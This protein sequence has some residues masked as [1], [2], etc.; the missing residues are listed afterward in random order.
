MRGPNSIL[1]EGSCN[2]H[3][4]SSKSRQYKVRAELTTP[5]A[6][7]VDVLSWVKMKPCVSE[8]TQVLLLPGRRLD[9]LQEAERTLQ[10]PSAEY[11]ISFR[12]NSIK[13]YSL[14]VSI[15]A[16]KIALR[17]VEKSLMVIATVLDDMT[18]NAQ[19]EQAL[20]ALVPVGSGR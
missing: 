17:T 11:E 7:T 9:H 1:A 16:E 12:E 6:N 4:R 10:A 8:V 18:I 5:S 15:R 2:R 3:Q 13:N 19:E 20:R 14:V